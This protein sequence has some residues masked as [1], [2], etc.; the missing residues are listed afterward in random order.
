[1]AKLSMNYFSNALRR[2]VEINVILPIDNFD[3]GMG[4]YV[5][6]RKFKTLYLLHGIYGSNSDWITHS[7]LMAYLAKYNIAV[8][9]PSGEN[10]FYV[11]NTRTNAMYSQ[12]IGEELPMITRR[13]FPLSD[14][15]ED[16]FIAGLSMGGFGALLN[17][18]KYND[19]FSVIGAFSSAIPNEL[20]SGDLFP[21][22]DFGVNFKDL[23]HHEYNQ[24]DLLKLVDQKKTNLPDLYLTCG[25]E[26]FIYDKTQS[27]IA[28]LNDMNLKYEYHEWYGEHSWEFWDESIKKFLEYLDKNKTL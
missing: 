1:M 24:F 21:N 2:N 17:G 20:E 27:F 23:L 10:S 14:K 3:Y 25:T 6:N 28:S 9:L 4:E 15:K 18:I 11:D 13:A 16:T 22:Y 7:N 12:F 26:D 19:T 8:V 5:S